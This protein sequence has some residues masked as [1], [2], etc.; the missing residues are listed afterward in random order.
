MAKQIQPKI[1]TF[2]Y[3]KVIGV[4]G[5]G[6]SAVNRMIEAGV[7]DV[8][9]IVIN[10]DAQALY[11]SKAETK[12]NIGPD[13]TRGLGA[14]GDPKVGQEAA[15]ESI[16][17]IKQALEGA[18]MIFLTLGAGGGTGSGAAHVVAKAA[19][20]MGILVIAFVT[21]PFSFEVDRRSR[22]ADY[23]ISNLEKNVDTLVIIPNDNLLKIIDEQTPVKEAFKIADDILRQ[24]VQGIADLIINNGLINLDFADIRSIMKDAGQALMGIG[25][26]SGEDRAVLA[27][28]QAINSP[29][30]GISIHGAKGVLFNII[31]GSDMTMHEINK[32]ANVITDVADQDVNVIYGTVI[33]PDLDGEIIVTVI[34]TGFDHHAVAIGDR[35][36]DDS[37]SLD[38]DQDSF[39]SPPKISSLDD[40][41]SLPKKT[42]VEEAEDAKKDKIKEESQEEVTGEVET[43]DTEEIN[44]EESID[45]IMKEIENNQSETSTKGNKT[46]S[47][48]SDLEVLNTESS[49]IEDDNDSNIWDDVTLDDDD[50]NVDINK[51]TLIRKIVAKRRQRKENKNK[52]TT[53]EDS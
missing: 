34:A 40:L 30:L 36:I 45:D 25:R 17:D 1:Q 13:T 11:H 3:I 44:L 20:E 27:A 37:S 33:D 46:K 38:G 18:D 41:P 47:D 21:K 4:G 9:F 52:K 39:L 7:A 31:G 6:G 12:L 24:G 5:A 51:P 19:R 26:A 14:G 23:A 10:T 8:E 29:L 35:L 43:D 16:E 15:Q 28:Q 48:E 42:L 2:A 22:N 50:Y 53:E 49:I 32:A